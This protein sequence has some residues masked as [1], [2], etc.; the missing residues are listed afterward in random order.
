MYSPHAK[1]A[2]AHKAFL[3]DGYDR[4]TL[5]WGR[6]VG[7]SLWSV[8]HLVIAATYKKGRIVAGKRY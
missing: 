5:F 6:Q 3:T 2:E 7:K 4:G 1:Q 8:M